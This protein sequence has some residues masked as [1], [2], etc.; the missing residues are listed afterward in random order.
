[1]REA[2]FCP[3]HKQ[4]DYGPSHMEAIG[5]AKSF[6]LYLYTLRVL[7]FHCLICIDFYHVISG[8]NK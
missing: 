1:M 6:D 4:K 5:P 8:K 7:Y 2:V 3:F